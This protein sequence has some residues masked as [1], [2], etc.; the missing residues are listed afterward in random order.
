M[1]VDANLYLKLLEVT[2]RMKEKK[3]GKIPTTLSM[4]RRGL[5]EGMEK[6]HI[7]DSG[8]WDF[9]HWQLDLFCGN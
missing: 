6:S 7:I 4:F 5:L 8:N 3:F 9:E 1:E 2:D